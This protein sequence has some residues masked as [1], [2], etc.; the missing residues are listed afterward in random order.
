[1]VSLKPW[2]IVSKEFNEMSITSCR[3]KELSTVVHNKDT[4]T[5]RSAHTSCCEW[6]GWYTGA[7]FDWQMLGHINHVGI[8]LKFFGRWVMLDMDGCAIVMGLGLWR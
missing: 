8:M 7:I 5:R 6:S 4:C 1:M 2:H 3:C